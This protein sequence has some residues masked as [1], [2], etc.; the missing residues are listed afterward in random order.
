[1]QNSDFLLDKIYLKPGELVVTE[2]PVMVTTV[3]GSCVSVTMFNARTGT[4]AICHGML[5][6]GGKS[7]NFK[8]VDTALRYMLGYF[9]KLQIDRKEIEVKFFGGADMFTTTTKESNTRN[10][11]VG[12]QNI[13]AATTCLKEYGLTPTA[14]DVGGGIGRKLIFTT[15]TG[16]V[17]LKRLRDQDRFPPYV[18]EASRQVARQ[19]TR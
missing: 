16:I 4:A 8:Y 10:L 11:T 9:K 17:Y 7:E 6:Y 14:S 15:D 13:S 12:W 1:M 2:E 5:P 18:E 3:L 19:L